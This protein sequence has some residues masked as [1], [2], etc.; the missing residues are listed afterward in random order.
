MLCG[1]RLVE[2]LF[3]YWVESSRDVRESL[4]KVRRESYGLKTS[5]LVE[6]HHVARSEAIRAALE[7]EGADA[8]EDEEQGLN[9]VDC[10]CFEVACDGFTCL[11]LLYNE[12]DAEFRPLFGCFLTLSGLRLPAVALVQSHKIADCGVTVEDIERP[13][14]ALAESGMNVFV[15][16]RNA[17]TMIRLFEMVFQSGWMLLVSWEVYT[18]QRMSKL[19]GNDW[20]LWLSCATSVFALAYGVAF[21]YLNEEGF[22]VRF[23]VCLYLF[24]FAVA[25]FTMHAVIFVEFGA[26]GWYFTAYVFAVRVLVMVYRASRSGEASK[27]KTA[28]AAE[29]RVTRNLVWWEYIGFGTADAFLTFLLPL[30]RL[31]RRARSASPAPSDRRRA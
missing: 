9:V 17:M 13:S 18:R 4:A 19:E 16:G 27:E 26:Y 1:L 30:V 22:V 6:S 23:L 10:C 31:S 20:R 11:S 21:T 28:D 25:R 12:E 15:Q 7:V 2:M 5:A 3:F 8:G 24:L 14:D 29:M